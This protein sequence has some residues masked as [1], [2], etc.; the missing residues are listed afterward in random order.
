MPEKEEAAVP[1]TL[2]IRTNL[3]GKLS[4]SL[5]A[6]KKSLKSKVTPDGLVVTIPQAMRAELAKQEGV[7]IKISAGRS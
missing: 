3:K 6:G 1:E 2:T 4:V 5:L 7:V